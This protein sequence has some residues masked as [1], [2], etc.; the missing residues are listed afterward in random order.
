[1]KAFAINILETRYF[2]LSGVEVINVSVLN[3]SVLSSDK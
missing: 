2:V 3:A 1:M